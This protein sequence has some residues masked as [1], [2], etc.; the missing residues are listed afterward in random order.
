MTEELKK[1]LD[2]ISKKMF[3]MLALLTL[4]VVLPVRAESVPDQNGLCGNL[5]VV[6]RGVLTDTGNICIALCADEQEWEHKKLPC[7]T[8]VVQV[9]K[10]QAEHIF[11]DIPYGEYALK[12]F[13]D[14]NK[15]E[16]LDKNA[17]GSPVEEYGFSQ[18]ARGRFGPPSFKSALFQFNHN[19]T[20]LEILV[21]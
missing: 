20:R 12:A 4:S 5:M 19:H 7:R 9:K 8:A 10:G 18:N 11:K 17:L 1:M 3:L 14:E 6:I 21:E 13:H 2:Y 15:N 16:Q